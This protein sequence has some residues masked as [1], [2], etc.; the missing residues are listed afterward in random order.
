MGMCKK[1]GKVY[2]DTDKNGSFP[3]SSATFSKGSYASPMEIFLLDEEILTCP[4]DPIEAID[5]SMREGDRVQD[6]DLK[7]ERQP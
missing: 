1:C 5:E 4:A 6:H 2:E 7:G 3:F